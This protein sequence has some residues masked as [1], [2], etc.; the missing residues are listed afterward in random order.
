MRSIALERFS[1]VGTRP[2][3]VRHVAIQVAMIDAGEN[4]LRD[5]RVESLAVDDLAGSVEGTRDCHV[6]NVVVPVAERIIALAVQAR[7]LRRAEGVRIQACE[8]AKR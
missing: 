7:I 8:A 4:P 6:Q 1:V 2:S 5:H 3:E